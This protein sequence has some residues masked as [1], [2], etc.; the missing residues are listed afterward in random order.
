M[1][2]FV[3]KEDIYALCPALAWHST[4]IGRLFHAEGVVG[5]YADGMVNA[6]EVGEELKIPVVNVP[7]SL[8]VIKMKNMAK[9]PFD[10]ED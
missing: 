2:G 9:D 1:P 7:H 8:G 4:V 10:Q 3:R 6:V 5:H